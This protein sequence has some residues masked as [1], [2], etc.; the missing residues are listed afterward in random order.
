MSHPPKL[1]T[2][3]SLQKM[4]QNKQPI[5]MITAYD[6]PSG[7]LAET[8]G[9]DIIL[10]GDSVGMVVLG[11]ESTVRVTT[12]DM[13][14]HTRAVSRGITRPL[15]VADLP[16]LTYHLSTRDALL[17]AGKLLQE[18]G[19]TAI[20]MEGGKQLAPTVKACVQAGIPVMGHIGLKPQSVNQT[21][22]RIEGKTAESVQKLK[23]DAEALTEAGVFAIVLE[24]VTEEAAEII[25]NTVPVPT[26]GIGSGRQCDGQVLVFHDVL[27]YGMNG[28]IPSFVKTYADIG[29]AIQKGLT[30]YVNDVKAR[31]FPQSQHIFHTSE[32]LS[33]PPDG[34]E[35]HGHRNDN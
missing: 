16:F 19:A 10:V 7:Q 27:Q 8:S 33:L 13:V 14:H 1:V 6:F 25:T 21:G 11:Y 24:C 30:A 34:G 28:F 22:Y 32:Q 9:A 4:K 12:A 18:G 2:V 26:I 23:E 3:A 17:A 31:Q 5:A 29:E 35:K 20:K 15:L